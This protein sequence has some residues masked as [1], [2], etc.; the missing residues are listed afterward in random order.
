[1]IT[2]NYNLMGHRFWVIFGLEAPSGFGVKV[3]VGG[4]PVAAWEWWIDG[5]LNGWMDGGL[6]GWMD[7]G[8]NGWMDG[9]LNGWMDGWI[10][11]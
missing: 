9:G 6:N 3:A 5:G 10:E 2:V 11:G 7:G 1:M 4:E 8:L